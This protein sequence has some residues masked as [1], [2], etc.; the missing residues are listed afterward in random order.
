MKT[1][2]VALLVFVLVSQGEA[3]KCYCGGRNN[4]PGNE[5]ICTT[6]HHLCASVVYND[7]TS[8]DY[9]KGC[10]SYP[11]CNFIKDEPSV[12]SIYCCGT[13]LCNT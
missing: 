12:A 10:A 3:L 13:D 8:P 4:C 1:F 9:M 6:S 11:E 2:L 7:G 5:E